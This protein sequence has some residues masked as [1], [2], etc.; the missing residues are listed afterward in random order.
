MATHQGIVGPGRSAARVCA[1][2]LRESTRYVL[3]WALA[4][5]AALVAL[6]IAWTLF[7]EPR[8]ADHNLGH[9]HIDFGGQWVMGRMLIEGHGRFLYNRNYQWQ[10]VRAA[11]PRHDEIPPEKLTAEEEKDHQHDADK[12]MGAFLGTDDP[13]AVA[14]LLPPLAARGPL[15]AATLTACGKQVWEPARLAEAVAAR[16]GPLYPPLHAFLYSPLALLRPQ[17]AYRVS[18]VLGLLL[19]FGAG[20]GVRLLTHGRIWWPLAAAAVIAF[21]GFADSLELGQNSA[22]TLAVLVWGWVLVARGRPGCGGVVWGLLAFK[23][24][25]ALAFFLVPLLTRRWRACLAMVATGVMLAALTL[26][27]VGWHAWVDWFRVGQE[28][29]AT[30]QGD[31]NWIC[32]SRDL[33]GIPRRWLDFSGSE[34]SD[35]RRRQEN[36][37]ATVAGWVLLGGVLGTTVLLALLRRHQVRAVTGPP[38]AFLLLGAW[39]SCFHFMYYDVLLAALPVLLLFTEPWRYLVPVFLPRGRRQ[40]PPPGAGGGPGSELLAALPYP[41]AAW[42]VGSG[43]RH[44]WVLNRAVPTL[45][46]ALLVAHVPVEAEILPW[47][48]L[49][50]MVLWL[51]CGWVVWRMPAGHEAGQPSAAALPAHAAQLVQFGPDVG[52]AH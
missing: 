22:L 6:W 25:W 28:A 16:G 17:P 19:A 14:A 11:Y 3:A 50:L 23:P 43:R 36:L 40:D 46:V 39:L 37:P 7:D 51:W 21:P 1:F 12:L 15:E 30:Y 44:V 38:A 34:P 10:A 20:W 45:V 35:L 9:T 31:R 52:G 41:P 5:G 33:L 13:G 48:T 29:S 4:G 18:Q 32:F 47:D 27:A 2:L 49:C 8:R 24:V 26:P 42:P